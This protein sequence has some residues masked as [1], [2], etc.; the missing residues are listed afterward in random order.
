VS[1]RLLRLLDGVWGEV[2]PV[3]Q[4]AETRTV[5][6]ALC[7]DADFDLLGRLPELVPLT[8]ALARLEVHGAAITLRVIDDGS[9][10]L[11]TD[12]LDRLVQAFRD[13]DRARAPGSSREGPR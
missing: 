10:T 7:S 8:T 9:H 12:D 11:D 1:G 3:R 5:A 6:V 13:I 4:G 2:R